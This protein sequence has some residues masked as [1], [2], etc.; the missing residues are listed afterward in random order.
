MADRRVT[1][2]RV[3]A[4][5]PEPL[6]GALVSGLE[7]HGDNLCAGRLFQSPTLS[8][9]AGAMIRQLN[10]DDFHGG[11]LR[12]LMH[13]RWRKRAASYGGE[14]RAGMHASMIEA[15]YDRA[16]FN[17]L[18]L[19]PGSHTRDASR[20]VGRWFLAEAEREL[21]I[22][23]NRR[24]AGLAPVVNWREEPLRRWDEGLER[25][26]PA[27]PPEAD[28]VPALAGACAG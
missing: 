13:H 5:L 25:R 21:N 11:R 16:V 12:F 18:H 6:L 10:P 26:I 28:R 3:L 9:A 19:A 15:C 24:A 1:L 17:T 20:L 14:F 4:D 7:I 27:A 23:D 22:R 2:R 8:C